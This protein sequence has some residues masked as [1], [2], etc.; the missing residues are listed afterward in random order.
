MVILRFSVVNSSDNH[1]IAILSDSL[2]LIIV[3]SKIVGKCLGKL[4][5]L[6][7][8]IKATSE[9]QDTEKSEENEK[10]NILLKKDDGIPFTGPELFCGL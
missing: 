8:N 7:K 6:A 10:R 2:S 9:V 1:D 4:N 5:E 3:S